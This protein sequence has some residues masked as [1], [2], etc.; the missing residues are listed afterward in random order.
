MLY[1]VITIIVNVNVCHFPADAQLIGQAKCAHAVD[2]AE[3]DGFGLAAHLIGDKA[4]QHLENF[5][6]PMT[7]AVVI[8]V[9]CR[10]LSIDIPTP[11]WTSMDLMRNNFV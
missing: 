4:G 9:I 10:W 7:Y 8:A 1:E 2:D 6:M 3:I 11:L 5:R